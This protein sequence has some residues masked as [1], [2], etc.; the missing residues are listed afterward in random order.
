VTY[1]R[2]IEV[3]YKIKSERLLYIDYKVVRS[4]VL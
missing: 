2:R 3:I 1:S 4:R